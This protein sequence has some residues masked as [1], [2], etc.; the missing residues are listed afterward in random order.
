MSLT[1]IRNYEVYK[2]GKIVVIGQSDVKAE[3]LLSIAKKL[4]LD[5]SHFESHLD[6]DDAKNFNFRKTQWQPSYSLIMVGPMPH[7]GFG[8]GDYSKLLLTAIENQGKEQLITDNLTI[9]HIRGR[10]QR[11]L[12]KR[13]RR[14]GGNDKGKAGILLT[15]VAGI[16]AAVVF[17][18]LLRLRDNDEFPA[19]ELLYGI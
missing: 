11:V 8:K 3:V 2:T 5:K 10:C 12:H 17:Q 15:L 9:E 4:G 14:S 19:D 18:N 6:Y 13:R 7:S 16:G 1:A